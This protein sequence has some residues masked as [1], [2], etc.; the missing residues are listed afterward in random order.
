MP[1]STTMPRPLMDA[2]D[3]LYTS[4]NILR[5]ISDLLDGRDGG[6]LTLSEQG[7]AGLSTLVSECARAAHTAYDM[8]LAEMRAREPSEQ[9]QS[10]YAEGMERGRAQVF[11]DIGDP[12]THST[13]FHYTLGYEDALR[14]NPNKYEGATAE[15]DPTPDAEIRTACGASGPV[16]TLTEDTKPPQP[17]AARA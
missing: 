14:G 5:L 1:T 11:R 4:E 6:D 16:P 10:G 12:G 9:Y 2:I 7:T 17:A 8:T 13:V 3:A 15:V